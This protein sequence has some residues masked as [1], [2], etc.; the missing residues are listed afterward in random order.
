MVQQHAACG[1]C[2]YG[3]TSLRSQPASDTYEII[4]GR[5]TIDGTEETLT[6]ARPDI[7]GRT[8]ELDGR[9][10]TVIAITQPNLSAL[11]RARRI[12]G[13]TETRT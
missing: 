13:A 2:V 9:P 11:E 7:I 5:M 8:V 4:Q 12:T 6:G 3:R 10:A 1:S